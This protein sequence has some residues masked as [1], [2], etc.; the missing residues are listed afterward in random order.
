MQLDMNL[1]RLQS[2]IDVLLIRLSQT[3][4]A[5][6]L[7]HLFLLNNY[8]MAISVLKEAG[9][10]AKKLQRHFEEKLETNMMAFVVKQSSHVF[11]IRYVLLLSHKLTGW[12]QLVGCAWFAS[13]GILY[14][15]LNLC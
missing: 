12:L 3:F 15:L 1:E 4:T 13:S 2:A 6:K 11:S 5:T 10:E 8:D 7:Q 9:D 14:F